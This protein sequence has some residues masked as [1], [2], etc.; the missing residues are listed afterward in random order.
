MKPNGPQ[1]FRLAKGSLDG[2]LVILEQPARRQNRSSPLLPRGPN[3]P[4]SNLHLL[5]GARLLRD[6]ATPIRLDYVTAI[7]LFSG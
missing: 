2:A 1:S 5:S 3:L 6:A 7:C 4:I